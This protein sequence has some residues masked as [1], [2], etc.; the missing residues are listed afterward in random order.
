MRGVIMLRDKFA[1]AAMQGELASQRHGT[2]WTDI[3]LLA[4]RAYKVSDAMMKER[5]KQDFS[6]DPD[7]MG[8]K[9]ILSEQNNAMIVPACNDFTYHNEVKEALRAAV[10]RK[11]GITHHGNEDIPQLIH[12]LETGLVF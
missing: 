1:M 11:H 7:Y 9:A 2:E 3:E 6:V 10:T 5:A 12:Q 8:L 4:S